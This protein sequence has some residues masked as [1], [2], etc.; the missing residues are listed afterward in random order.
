MDL[1]LF[2]NLAKQSTERRQV[3]VQSKMPDWIPEEENMK[4]KKIPNALSS[5]NWTKQNTTQTRQWIWIERAALSENALVIADSLLR[6]FVAV[7]RLIH[8]SFSF[9]F[10]K[11]L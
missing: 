9:L 1:K 7:S 2:L 11:H 4:H 8:L 3:K 10:I 5:P 6:H